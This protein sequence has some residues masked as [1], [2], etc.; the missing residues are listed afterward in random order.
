MPRRWYPKRPSRISRLVSL[1]SLSKVSGMI[2]TSITVDGQIK[3]L[4][5][6]LQRRDEE[7]QIQKDANTR[8]AKQLDDIPERNFQALSACV[9][10]ILEKLDDCQLRLLK[11]SKAVREEQRNQYVSESVRDT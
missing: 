4:T 7:V 5:L 2:L 1:A 8:L 9:K 11:D 3:E 6:Q 10:R